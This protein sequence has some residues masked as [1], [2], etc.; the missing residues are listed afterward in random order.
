MRFHLACLA[1]VVISS[2]AAAQTTLVAHYRLDE[3]SGT[4]ASDSSGNGN[5]GVY[6]GA[7]ITL[8][9]TGTC[10]SSRAVEFDGATGY[11][12]IPSSASLD[13]LRSNFTVAAWINV[14]TLGLMRV[15]GNQ[16][17]GGV[18]GSWAFGPW[19]AAGGLRLTTLGVQDYNQA[20]SLTAATWRHIAVVFDDSFQAS[21]YLDGVLQGTVAGSAQ[22]N[23]PN[24]GWFIGVLD[25]TGVM[26]FFD[27]RID[28][29][30]IYSGSATAADITSLFLNPCGTLESP[31]VSSCN[32]D[33]GNQFGCTNCP[34]TNDSP[35]GTIGGCE[36]S[37]GTA[38][39][40]MSFGST[41][42]AVGNLRLEA[43]GLPTTSTCL[44]FSGSSIAPVNMANPCFSLNSGVQSVALDGLRCV[45]QGILRHGLRAADTNGDVGVTN[46]GWGTPSP[47][48]NFSTFLSGS[49]RHFQLIHTDDPL[50][51]CQRGLN[52][53]QALS[54]AF[55]P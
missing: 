55:T 34:C 43:A 32:G 44:L 26:E 3:T 29:V 54:I 49:T 15:F 48:V 5:D 51:V 23:A 42:I 17:L 20:S 19:N 1:T 13:G 31:G 16:R 2:A 38:S 39:E 30:Q 52:S 50:V 35:V 7:G 11:V 10:S 14:D 40:L 53:S 45:A 41:S 21:F 25:L 18:G 24:S 8:G 22:A 28:D 47:F 9:Q 46:A 33:N 12:A 27:G 37:A 4:T 36:N 6:T